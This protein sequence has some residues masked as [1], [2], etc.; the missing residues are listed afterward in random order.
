[1]NLS[2]VTTRLA[3]IP[4]IL[5]LQPDQMPWQQS[6]IQFIG[7]NPQ[8]VQLY[9]PT[10]LASDGALTTRLLTLDAVAASL[11]QSR[12]LADSIRAVLEGTPRE[13]SPYRLLRLT[14]LPLEGDVW[15][16]QFNFEWRG[17]N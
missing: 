12:A 13:P 10:T 15:R 4:D 9:E 1:M 2:D 14:P 8:F 3:A 7:S 5:V 6:L 11:E 17:A 16:H